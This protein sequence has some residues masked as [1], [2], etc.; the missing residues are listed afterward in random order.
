[1]VQPPRSYVL[2]DSWGRPLVAPPN[3]GT[4]V[5]YRRTTTFVD[6]LENT[7]GLT[8]WKLR[9]LASGLSHRPDLV[10]AIAAICLVSSSR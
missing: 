10:L 1:M 7:A 9:Q 4:R 3:G 8:R 6:A 2:R 5:P